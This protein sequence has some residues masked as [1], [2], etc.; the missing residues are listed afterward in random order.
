M[1]KVYIVTVRA[2]F[3]ETHDTTVSDEI[4]RLAGEHSK[5]KEPWV[6]VAK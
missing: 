5:L 3:H 6:F 1:A 4:Y 2:I